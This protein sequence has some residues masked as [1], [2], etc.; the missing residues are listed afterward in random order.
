MD[1][2]EERRLTKEERKAILAQLAEEDRRSKEVSQPTRLESKTDSE[3]KG[4]DKKDA[5]Y[6]RI[7]EERQRKNIAREK[8]KAERQQELKTAEDNNNKEIDYTPKQHIPH[9]QDD[10][11]YVKSS[12]SSDGEKNDTEPVQAVTMKVK[13]TNKQTSKK[14]PKTPWNHLEMMAKVVTTMN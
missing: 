9:K 4:D 5:E 2:Q 12:Y 13:K 14:R 1:E 3:D 8:R 6:E 11:F 7:L 10:K